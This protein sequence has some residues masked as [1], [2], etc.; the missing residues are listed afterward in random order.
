MDGAW[1]D[2]LPVKWVMEQGATDI[3]I[4]RTQPPNLRE[5]QSWL[6]YWG[7]IYYHRHPELKKVFAQNHHNYNKT[8]DFINDP[9]AGIIIRQ[10]YPDE[11]LK[12][13]LY[14]NSKQAL[15]EDYNYG[16]RKGSR[17]LRKNP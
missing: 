14:T 9:P 2:P 8:I 10:V 7:E 5:E 1:G 16:I 4:V 15:E 3:T 17:F 11:V 6:D 13:G 12:A